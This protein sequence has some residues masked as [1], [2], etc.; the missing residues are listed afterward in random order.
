MKTYE[1]IN[2]LRAEIKTART[3]YPEISALERLTESL[4]I[5]VK[6]IH[7]S[8]TTIWKEVF[9]YFRMKLDDVYQRKKENGGEE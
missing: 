7:S 2:K 1:Q 8:E 3:N 9:V 6:E 4:E 5:A